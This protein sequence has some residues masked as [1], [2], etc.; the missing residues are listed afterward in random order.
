[1]MQLTTWKRVGIGYVTNNTRT[2]STGIRAGSTG[3]SGF[4]PFVLV[5]LNFLKI[6]CHTEA[7][8]HCGDRN[9][10]HNWRV[11]L[12]HEQDQ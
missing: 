3:I 12:K 4:V 2:Q 11:H 6:E 7:I 1:M 10:V 5:V 9:A 8:Q